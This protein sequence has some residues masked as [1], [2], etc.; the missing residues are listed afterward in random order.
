MYHY[1]HGMLYTPR[2]ATG[3]PHTSGYGAQLVSRLQHTETIHAP[4]YPLTRVYLGV[5]SGWSIWGVQ[6]DI[7]SD[8][9]VCVHHHH[10]HYHH[11]DECVYSLQHDYSNYHYPSSGRCTPTHKGGICAYGEIGTFTVPERLKHVLYFDR[12][13][14]V[15]APVLR[16]V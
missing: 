3:Q 13:Q 2:Y 9:S 12:S 10:H 16:G 15:D 6:S 7:P 4:D 14:G 5:Y 8:A 1:T 11:H